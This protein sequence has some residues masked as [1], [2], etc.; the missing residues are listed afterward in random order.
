MKNLVDDLLTMSEEGRLKAVAKETPK[1]LADIYCAIHAHY[2]WHRPVKMTVLIAGG[3]YFPNSGRESYGRRRADFE[4]ETLS[5][6]RMIER[7][8]SDRKNADREAAEKAYWEARGITTG[9]SWFP[10]EYA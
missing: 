6:L 3:W 5:C 2:E 7:G 4:A 10:A 1:G 9:V 8:I